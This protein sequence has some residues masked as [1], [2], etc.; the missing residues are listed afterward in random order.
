MAK[1]K[2]DKKKTNHILVGGGVLIFNTKREVLLIKRGAGSK[3]EKFVWQKPGG[4]VDLG[5]TVIGAM[6]RE[7]KEETGISIDIWGYL[8]HTDSIILESEGEHWVAFNYLANW[9]SGTAIIMEPKKHSDIG[10]FSLKNLPKPLNRLTKDSIKNYLAG[11]Y[12]K[13]K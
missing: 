7:I 8:P 4:A 1:K 2:T 13:L 10:W 3:R 5:E 11:K 6:K 12:I 9:K